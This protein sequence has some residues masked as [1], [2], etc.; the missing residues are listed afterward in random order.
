MPTFTP[1][2]LTTAEFN[3]LP[4]TLS[5]GGVSSAAP[6]VTRILATAQMLSASGYGSPGPLDQIRALHDA[7]HAAVAEAWSGDPFTALDVAT[8][9]PA[10]A[11]QIIRDLATSRVLVV[12]PGSY[13]S[14][15]LATATDQFIASL[16][17]AAVEAFAEYLTGVAAT[18]NREFGKAAAKV[19]K[20][21]KSGLTS[22]STP[23]EILSSGSTEQ[24]T[25]YRDLI[26]ATRELDRLFAL[27][28][29]AIRTLDPGADTAI[30]IAAF[31]TTDDAVERE[32]AA[33]VFAGDAETV[34]VASENA[35]IGPSVHKVTKPRFGGVWLALVA[36]GYKLTLRVPPPAVE[37]DDTLADT[38]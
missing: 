35:S 10:E 27:W 13:G 3:S 22:W 15:G 21:V 38:A 28:A 7:A 12:S 24:I 18:L 4:P 5:T 34:L 8:L 23:T 31:V 37:A 20:A 1:R 2:T 6:I 30:V 16:T 25:A 33:G 29:P 26:V 32:N 14:M 11:V 17:P 36:A 9:D 19:D